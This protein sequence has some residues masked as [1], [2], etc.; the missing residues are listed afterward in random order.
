MKLEVGKRYLTRDG[1]EAVILERGLMTT[2]YG[3]FGE[4]IGTVGG[5]RGF[6]WRDD[7][8]F[9][10][11]EECPVDLVSE[12]TTGLNLHIGG[13]YL[14]ANGK[15]ATICEH[16]PGD[17]Y[18]WHGMFGTTDSGGMMSWSDVGEQVNG[19]P[20]Y[21]LT[22]EVLS[23]IQELLFDPLGLG[24]KGKADLKRYADGLQDSDIQRAK[25]GVHTDFITPPTID[26]KTSPWVPD[27]HEL[28]NDGPEPPPA[29]PD[30]DY[31]HEL[32]INQLRDGLSVRIKNYAQS[33]LFV[34]LGIAALI[35]STA[36]SARDL[37][38]MPNGVGG[39][40]VLTDIPANT[41]NSHVV[42]SRAPNG[43][44]IFGRWTPGERYIVVVW[45]DTGT[46]KLFDY[47]EFKMLAKRPAPAGKEA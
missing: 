46:V 17:A 7:G 6:E 30:Y 35:Y 2:T 5:R 38:S 39:E 34:L 12:I 25:Q 10:A 8:R 40:I 13:R 45:D 36:A 3:E 23:D 32:R 4:F 24:V 47:T 19:A 29:E 21:A 26:F 1:L 42:Y 43:D 44:T 11:M 41:G 37:A 22:N 16:R 9:Y 18:P 28:F 15:V 27:E 33:I 14:M 20:Q 31:E